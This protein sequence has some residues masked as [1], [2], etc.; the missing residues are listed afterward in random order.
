MNIID[1]HALHEIILYHEIERGMQTSRS[2]SQR[3]LIPELVELS[4]KDFFS[5]I[6]LKGY[7]E[8]VGI[9]IDEFGQHTVVIRAF[10][11]F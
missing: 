6:S 4:P 7:L 9:E 8:S 3:L 2:P 1:Q 5:V 10:H 11:R